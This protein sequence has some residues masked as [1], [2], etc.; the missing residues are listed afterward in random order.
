MIFIRRI[1]NFF[2]S[3]INKQ[4]HKIEAGYESIIM[5][6]DDNINSEEYTDNLWYADKS[7]YTSIVNFIKLK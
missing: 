4:P 2:Y 6:D 1:R 3:L 7:W 5:S